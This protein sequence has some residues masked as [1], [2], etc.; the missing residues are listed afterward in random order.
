MPCLINTE[1]V[2]LSDGK[3]TTSK[4]ELS[5]FWHKQIYD[6]FANV[7]AKTLT[8]DVFVHAS[9]NGWL[10][11]SDERYYFVSI[12]FLFYNPFRNMIIGLPPKLTLQLD[13]EIAVSGFTTNPTCSSDC[14]IFVACGCSSKPR[15]ICR[16]FTCNLKDDKWT[17]Q[18]IHGDKELWDVAYMD[19][20]FY[21]V[22]SEGFS[23]VMDT[24]TFRS[25]DAIEFECDM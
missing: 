5:D 9:K 2:L 20:A 18:D 6:S 10:L 11:L 14:H 25:Y 7:F 4:C 24:F 8:I 22:F 12:S 15:R 19:G 1:Y 23:I 13:Q 17:S 21:C 3:T 16:I